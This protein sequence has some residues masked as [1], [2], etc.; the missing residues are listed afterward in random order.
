MNQPFFTSSEVSAAVETVALNIADIEL[1]FHLLDEQE[2]KGERR[3]LPAL[4]SANNIFF[5]GVKG[6][7]KT[8]V[9]LVHPSLFLSLSLSSLV[10]LSLLCR[11]PS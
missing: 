11:S 8:T 2:K 4:A 1:H 6:V 5:D 3:F 10:S 7:G 9:C